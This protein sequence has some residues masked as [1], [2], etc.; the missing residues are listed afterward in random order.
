MLNPL[1]PIHDLSEV[2]FFCVNL[3]EHI[4]FFG[5]NSLRADNPKHLNTKAPTMTGA[6]HLGVQA[7]LHQAFGKLHPKLVGVEPALQEGF[8][9]QASL[10]IRVLLAHFKKSRED[11]DVWACAARNFK[12]SEKL[13]AVKELID[14]VVLVPKKKKKGKAAKAQE[15]DDLQQQA[16]KLGFWE[17]IWAI[18]SPLKCRQIN[19]GWL[20]KI[21]FLGEHSTSRVPIASLMPCRLCSLPTLIRTCLMTPRA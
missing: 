8:S 12:G 4:W 16:P 15:W 20:R 18:N 13:D 1:D 6:A 7:C 3:V 5:L 19:L 2:V 21:D 9:N 14:K 10:S 17:V 11:E